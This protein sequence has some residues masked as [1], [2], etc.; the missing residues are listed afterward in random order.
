VKKLVCS[1]TALVVWSRSFFLV[2]TRANFL[3]NEDVL[4]VQICLLSL[5]V[6]GKEELFEN[7]TDKVLLYDDAIADCLVCFRD[8]FASKSNQSNE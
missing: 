5:V 3:Y 6:R 2:V 4:G 1:F 8:D 7:L